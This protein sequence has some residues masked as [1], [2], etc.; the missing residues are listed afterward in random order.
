MNSNRVVRA[1]VGILVLGSL[2]LG[3]GEIRSVYESVGQPFA[4]FFVFPNGVVAPGFSSLTP[5]SPEAS[6]VDY[7]DRVVEAPGQRV[8]S[9]RRVQELAAEA[10]VGQSLRYTLERPGA[11]S[12]EVTVP[13]EALPAA[14]GPQSSLENPRVPL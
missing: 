8:R 14:Y 13:V 10:G 4:G 6:G 1:A 11:G 12:L 7:L 9:G 3:A 5:N 2:I